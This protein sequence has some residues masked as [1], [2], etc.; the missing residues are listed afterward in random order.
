MLQLN[1]VV[2]T[3]KG[4]KQPMLEVPQLSIAAGEIVVLMGASGSGK[5]TLL[6]WLIGAPLPNFQCTGEVLLHGAPIQQL[7][8]EQRHIGIRLQQPWL[9]PHLTVLENLLFAL[10]RDFGSRHQ[11]VQHAEHLLTA[12]NLFAVQ[13][14]LPDTLS[15]GQAARVSLARALINNPQ[16]MLLDEPFSALDKATREQ[17]KT[18]TFN[19][20]MQAQLPCLLVTHDSGDCPTGA[21]VIHV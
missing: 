4:A 9:F 6:N 10:P 5:S 17:I 16:A 8:M 2:I 7:P 13:K 12:F 15:G 1:N 20:L 3:L 19:H 21:R 11:R 18:F 14:Q